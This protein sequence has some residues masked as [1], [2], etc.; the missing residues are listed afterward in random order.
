LL[1]FNTILPRMSKRLHAKGQTLYFVDGNHEDFTALYK[2]PIS[3]DGLRWVRPNIVHLPRGYRTT[4]VSGRTLA[5]LGGANS[6]DFALRY[7]GD[8]CGRKSPSLKR[9]WRSWGRCTP[10]FW[11]GMTHPGACRP[12]IHG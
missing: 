6:V 3:A 5:A 4:L 8:N 10:M 7:V 1:T 9:I 11:S 2:F 12:W